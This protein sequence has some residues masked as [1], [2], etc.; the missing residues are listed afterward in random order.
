M[1]LLFGYVFGA[2]ISV[3]G[4]G[5]YRE[6][7]IPGLFAMT[8]LTAVMVT[9]TVVAAD[10]GR[11]VMD[12]F[13]S[14]PM[15]RS[16]VPFGQTV[17][18]LVTGLLSMA[19]MTGCALAVGWRARNGFAQTAAAFGVLVLFRYATAWVGVLLGL[20]FRNEEAAGRIVP[21]VFP[22]SMLSNTYVP[23]GSLPP[24]LRFV[25][26]WNPVSAVTAACRT[27]FG[28]PGSGAAQAALPLQHPVAASLIW[29]LALIAI[30]APVAVWRFA[31]AGR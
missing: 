4:N 12:R 8:S 25:A 13:R 30:C 7:L 6:Y 22:V 15:T 2:A 20:A 14:M 18:G 26:E 21:L 31:V 17:S 5:D 3:P 28:N 19:V 29:S 27:L 23:T 16:A 11:G 24:W 10:A 1:V 9:A